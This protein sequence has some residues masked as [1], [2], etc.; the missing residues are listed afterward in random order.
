VVTVEDKGL[1]ISRHELNKIF[2]PFYRSPAVKADQIHGSGLGLAIVKRITEAMGG[3]LA[4]QSELGKGSCFS[5]HLPAERKPLT[6][7]PVSIPASVEAGGT[8]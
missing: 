4:V 5:V 2:R 6:G 8:R 1:G 3:R 7:D